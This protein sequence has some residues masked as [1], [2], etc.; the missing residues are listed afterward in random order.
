MVLHLN[1]KGEYFDQI[2]IGIKKFEFR[3]FNDYWSKRLIGRRYSTIL[4]KR[5]YPKKLDVSKIIARPFLGYEIQTIQH[6]HFG[7]E[8]VKVFAITVN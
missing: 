7:P 2:K 3:L 6:E 1:L 8:P 4:I 5:G